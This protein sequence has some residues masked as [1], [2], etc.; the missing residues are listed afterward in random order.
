G[1]R[2][3]GTLVSVRADTEAERATAEQVL[4]GRGGVDA[5]QRGGVY[6]DA[7]W[8]QFDEA[9]APYSADEIAAERRRYAEARSFSG[10][11]VI[12][13]TA[14]DPSDPAQRPIDPTL[15]GI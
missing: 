5:L 6:R 8:A 12:D 15:R 4:N 11:G 10:Q 1:V 3:G 7:G 2:R 9:G 14:G 13:R